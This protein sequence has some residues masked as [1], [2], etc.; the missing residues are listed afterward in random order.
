MYE[1]YNGL[2]D[3]ELIEE[4]QGGDQVCFAVLLDRYKTHI[5]KKCLSYMKDKDSAA[6]L[7]QEVLIKLFLKLPEFRN[8]AKFSTWLYSIIHHT[9]IDLLRKQKKNT[10]AI[11]QDKLAEEVYEI[12]EFDEEISEQSTMDILEELLDQ[13]NPQEKLILVM[14]YKEKHHIKDIQLALGLSESAVKMRLKRSKAKLN[15]LYEL[16]LKQRKK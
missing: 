12:V 6:D 3:K 10:Q 8:E 9:C 1:K 16:S 2:S 14:K 4:F 13:L 7:S 5:Y 15:S 11:I